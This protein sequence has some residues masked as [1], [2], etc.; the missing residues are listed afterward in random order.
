MI[1]LL[2]LPLR[3]AMTKPDFLQRSLREKAIAV[4]AIVLGGFV[5]YTSFAGPFESLIQRAGFVAMISTLAVLMYPL[6]AGTRWRPLGIAIDILIVAVC[7]TAS[8]YIITNFD[9]I[10]TDLPLAGPLDIALAAGALL[11]VLELAR[12]TSNAV[13]PTLVLLSVAYAYFGY[14]IPGQFGHRGFDVGYL[15]EIVFLSDR[16]LW[17][18]LV[19]VAST[20]LAAFV[21]FGAMLLH[22]GAG[23]TFFDLS[24]R[25]GGSR[26][27]GAAKIATLASG[28]FGAIN[29]STVANVATTGNFTI[30]LMKRLNYPAAYAG[31]VE[32][33]ASTG[34][35][36]A[37]PIMGTAA[38]V[39]AEI[40]GINYWSIALAGVVPAFLFYVG[41]YVTVHVIARRGHFKAVDAKDLPDWRDALTLERI[42]PIIAAFGGLVF[43]IVNG[44]SVE[45]TA[46]YA[47]IAMV[48]AVALTRTL[49]GQSPARVLN[50]IVH[51]LEEGGRGVVIVGVL[52]VGAQV[53][54]AMINLTGL[55]VAVTGAV[56]SL[57]QGQ[58]WLI[59][60]L[61]ALVCLIAGMGLPTSAAY[62]LVAAVFAP[63]LIQQGLDPL[64]VHMF[65]LYYAALSV[66]TPPVCLGVFVAATIAQA[67]WLQVAMQTMRLGATAYVLPMLFLVYPGML[68]TGG[69]VAIVHALV[70]GGV[71]TLSAAHMLGGAAMKGG[72]LGKFVWLVPLV[73][74]LLPGWMPTIAAAFVFAG[75]FLVS[76]AQAKAYDRQTLV[77]AGSPA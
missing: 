22:S 76:Q 15:S 19:N 23:Q 41:V 38:F 63:A 70:S 61:M 42:A 36:L 24:A 59:A 77:A 75:L 71:F 73:L 33:V 64:T 21:L 18:M 2:L 44:N 12:R 68:G 14:L 47:M 40:I 50:I 20:T 74:A 6:F 9:Q 31:A 58:I 27:G 7:L 1:P 52:L 13:F 25:I 65:V 67:P 32:A 30:P 11:A 16:G 3:N 26:P 4:L 45:L 46:C 72:L 43:G 34:G 10:M 66:I 37:P 39:M 17:G 49:S 55:G 48:V 60:L 54:V 53:F 57:A 62:V 56:L 51:A 35:Q 69:P 29:G 8:G 28:F 5:F